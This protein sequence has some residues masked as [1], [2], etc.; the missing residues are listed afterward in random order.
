[1]PFSYLDLMRVVARIF[2]IHAYNS[3]K[4]INLSM[5]WGIISVY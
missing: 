2:V 4:Y 5:F 1:M 3:P